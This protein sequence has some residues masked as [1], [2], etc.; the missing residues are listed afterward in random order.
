MGL[1]EAGQRVVVQGP[2]SGGRCPGPGAAIQQ[3]WP[4]VPHLK[5]RVVVVTCPWSVERIK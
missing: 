1:E 3:V 4:Q 2:D 5:M